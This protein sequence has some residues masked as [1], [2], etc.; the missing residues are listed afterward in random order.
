MVAHTEAC[1][2]A[3]LAEGGHGAIEGDIAVIVAVCPV[4][5]VGYGVW[6]AHYYRPWRP[7][8]RQCGQA[9]IAGDVTGRCDLRCQ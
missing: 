7:M 8:Q 3:K 6:H 2:E 4:N 1:I 5:V 9:A